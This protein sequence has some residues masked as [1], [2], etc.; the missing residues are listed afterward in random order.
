MLKDIVIVIKLIT[1]NQN[2]T[3]KGKT[4]ILCRPI[5]FVHKNS[6]KEILL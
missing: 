2:S 5:K 3:S 4:K 1:L 6:N